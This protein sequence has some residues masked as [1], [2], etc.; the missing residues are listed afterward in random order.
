MPL[1]IDVHETLPEGTTVKD[2]IGP[3]NADLETQDGY[4]IKYLRYWV[5]ERNATSAVAGPTASHRSRELSWPSS[6][7]EDI[8]AYV[9]SR[10]RR[11][12]TRNPGPGRGRTRRVHPWQHAG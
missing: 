3:H 6:D 4:G 1:F 7:G 11:G 5:D 10:H 12:T 8:A 9:T 2:V